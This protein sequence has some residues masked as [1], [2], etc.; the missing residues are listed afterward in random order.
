MFAPQN[1]MR[2]PLTANDTDL[3]H[4]NCQRS[5]LARRLGGQSPRHPVAGRTGT[6]AAHLLRPDLPARAR[7]RKSAARL[8]SAKGRPHRHRSPRTAGSGPITDFATLAI[9]AANVPI[10][11]TLTGE[12]IG[13]LAPGCR[14]AGSPSSPRAS[15]STSS[16]PFAPDAARTH[17]HHGFRRPRPQDAIPFSELLAGADKRGSE[18]DPEFDALLRSVEPGR[19]GHAHLHLRHH[20]R[21]QG[22]DAHPRQHRRQS[23]LRGLRIRLRPQRRLHLLSPPLAHHRPRA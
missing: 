19:P 8:G 11:P 20:R 5:L 23:E 12:Q 9:G 1:E 6:L 16:T 15:S 3:F 14:A 13:D 7:A 22:R 18:R 17:R 21:A 2:R 10:Y 4:H